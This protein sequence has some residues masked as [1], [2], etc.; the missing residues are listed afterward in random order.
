MNSDTRHR[1][2]VTDKILSKT[3]LPLIPKWV[4]PNSI[5]WFRLVSIPLVAFLLIS[6][7][8]VPGLILFFLS[9]FS[10]AVDGA[11]TRTRDKITDWGKTLDPFAD[12]LLTGVAVVILASRFLSVYLAATIVTIECFLLA[13]AVYRKRAR[14]IPIEA[15]MSGKVKVVLQYIGICTLFLSAIFQM[16]VLLIVA[17]YSLY[18]A[19]LVALVSIVFYAFPSAESDRRFR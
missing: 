17:R 18:F 4:T 2:T 15:E 13:G 8:Y 5:T 16:P 1:L 11:L 6:E 14:G 7:R 9:A 3:F 10:D 19:I 12:K